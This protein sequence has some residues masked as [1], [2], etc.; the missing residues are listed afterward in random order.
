MIK[1]AIPSYTLLN[2]CILDGDNQNVFRLLRISRIRLEIPYL[3][4]AQ[5]HQMVTF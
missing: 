1:H 4:K 5:Y 3:F 2:I